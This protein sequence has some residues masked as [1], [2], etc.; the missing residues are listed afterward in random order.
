M[1]KKS[2]HKFVVTTVVALFI[3]SCGGGGSTSVDAAISHIEKVMAKIEKNKTSMT[4]ADWEVLGAE[5]EPYANVLN[6]ALENNQIGAMKKI[7]ISATLMR[8]A[9][10][11]GEAAMHT[12]SDSLKVVMEGMNELKDVFE[13]DEM[14]EAMQ[15]AQKALEE[16]QKLV[17]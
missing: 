15:E 1:M 11:V 10:V 14:Q 7:K 4:A 17:K 12:Y 6:D 16:L 9:V 5:L 8:W 2:I 13:S 3:V